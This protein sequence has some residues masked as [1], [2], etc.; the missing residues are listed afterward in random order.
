VL[1]VAALGACAT[2]DQRPLAL[3]DAR[4]AVDTA[5]ANPQVTTLAPAEL[6]DAIAAYQK[7]ETTYRAEGDSLEVRHLAYVARERRPRLFIVNVSR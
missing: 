4:I 7:A 5:R 3:E 6:N 1:A 2:V